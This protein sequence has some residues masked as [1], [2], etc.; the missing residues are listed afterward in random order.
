ML[1]LLAPFALITAPPPALTLEQS[2]ALKCGVAFAMADG[3]SPELRTRGREFFVRSA[4]R[5]MDETGAG[6]DAIAA[7]VAAQEDELRQDPDRIVAMMPVC[8]LLL[9]ASGL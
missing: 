8:L 4:A 2:T 9:D 7:L 6:R 5:I 3:A 1:L